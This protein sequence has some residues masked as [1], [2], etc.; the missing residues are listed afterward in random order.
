MAVSC[1]E[2]VNSNN[3]KYGPI[4]SDIL[5]TFAPDS[6]DGI[7]TTGSITLYLKTEMIYGCMNYE[8]VYQEDVQTNRIDIDIEGIVLPGEICATALGPARAKIPIGTIV[9]EFN[10]YFTYESSTDNHYVSISDSL[11]VVVPVDTSFIHYVDYLDG[12]WW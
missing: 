7:G 9:D 6:A 4:E 12:Q 3:G 5:F 10:L 2:D 1:E 11:V 8:I